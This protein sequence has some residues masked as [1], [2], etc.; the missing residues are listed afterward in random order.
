MDIHQQLIDSLIHEPI[1]TYTRLRSAYSSKS[2]LDK[3]MP[4][5]W[6]V[7]EMLLRELQSTRIINLVTQDG[8]LVLQRKLA[9]QDLR[10]VVIK[11]RNLLPYGETIRAI[12][13]GIEFFD[14]AVRFHYLQENKIELS[15]FAVEEENPRERGLAYYHRYRYLYHFHKLMNQ[16]PEV[17]ILPTSAGFSMLDMMRFRCVPVYAVGVSTGL[18]YVDEFEQT[19]IEFF[20]HDI[21]HARRQHDATEKWFAAR[22]LNSVEERIDVYKQS[23]E[24]SKELLDSIMV[25]PKDDEATAAIKNLKKV[26][27]FEVTHEDAEPFLPDV[28]GES[29]Q[30]VEGFESLFEVPAIDPETGLMDATTTKEIGITT[31]AYVRHKLQNG[32]YDK[33][34]VEGQGV[35]HKSYR[36]TEMIAK[37]AYELLRDIG[38]KPAVNVPADARGWVDQ[39]WLLERTCS[40]GPEIVH[41]SEIKDPELEKRASK[42][43]E[44]NKKR[45]FEYT[46][47]STDMAE[48]LRSRHSLEEAR[49][50]LAEVRMASDVV[51]FVTSGTQKRILLQKRDSAP[52]AGHW[53]LPGAFMWDGETAVVA[54]KRMLVNKLGITVADLRQIG[55][56]DSLQ[57]DPRGRVASVAFTAEI[58]LGELKKSWK[59]RVPLEE[60]LFGPAELPKLGFDHAQIISVAMV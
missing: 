54:A 39:A 11:S 15:Q 6:P 48:L 34:G 19:P 45:Y 14:I 8:G 25:S 4:E 20:M 56:F 5:L 18:T 40:Y 24:F 44:V 52:F 51:L 16:V 35:V 43:R 37:A 29:L 59:L 21:N 3:E 49:P 7:V 36:T 31:L 47:Q 30:R 28:I 57:R 27:L 13:R 50:A 33:I 38:Q 10:H 32:F 23:A 17:F 1:S 53:V 41:Q 46:S 60:Q 42:I 58:S 12:M 55:I 22:G 26:I 2:Q 9:L